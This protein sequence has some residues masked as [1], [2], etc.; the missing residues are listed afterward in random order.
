MNDSLFFEPEAKHK[1]LITRITL[2]TLYQLDYVPTT[3]WR[4]FHYPTGKIISGILSY[5]GQAVA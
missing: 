1:Q 2:M 4:R 3:A 5:N